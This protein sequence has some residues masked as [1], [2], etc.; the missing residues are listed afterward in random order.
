MHPHNRLIAVSQSIKRERQ[1]ELCL[2][3]CRAESRDKKAVQ[4]ELPSKQPLSRL[5]RHQSSQRTLVYTLVF[6]FGSLARLFH[7]FA[8]E[9]LILAIQ[10]GRR[11]LEIFSLLPFADNAFFFNHALKALNCFFQHLTVIYNNVSDSSSPPFRSSV[12]LLS[13][14]TEYRFFVKQRTLS[15]IVGADI[16]AGN[17]QFPVQMRASRQPGRA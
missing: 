13:H 11:L 7:Q 2:C 16:F 15:R 17:T 3:W 1:P 14:F 8:R 9:R 5:S 6:Y 12:K 4:K 10:Y